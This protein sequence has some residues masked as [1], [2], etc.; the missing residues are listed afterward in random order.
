MRACRDFVVVA[1]AILANFADASPLVAHWKMDETAQPVADSDAGA[2]RLV[3]QNTPGV[4]TR[5]VACSPGLQ[6][7]SFGFS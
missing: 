5:L 4:S 3:F 1:L 7:D 6:R 2:A